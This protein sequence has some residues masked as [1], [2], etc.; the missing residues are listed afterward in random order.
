[1]E[2]HKLVLAGGA[3]ALAGIGVGAFLFSPRPATAQVSPFREC[4]IARQESLD[5]NG[6]GVIAEAGLNFRIVIPPGWE[7]IGGGGPE[8]GRDGWLG[9]VILCRR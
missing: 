9:T 7:P 4:I 2:G 3:I 5:T 8:G 6:S 1:M